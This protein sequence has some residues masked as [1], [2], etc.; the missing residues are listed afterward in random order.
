M[1]CNSRIIRNSNFSSRPMLG[2]TIVSYVEDTLA[3][4]GIPCKE[5]S[6]SEQL[7][8]VRDDIPLVRAES[9][10]ELLSAST[11]NPHVMKDEDLIIALAIPEPFVSVHLLALSELTSIEE[12]VMLLEENGLPAKT[13]D[14]NHS[15]SHIAIVDAYEYTN[16]QSYLQAVIL[17]K[18]MDNGVLFTNPEN[19][20]ISP[21]VVIGKGTLVYGGNVLE[22]KTIIGSECILYPNNRMN[23]AFVGDNSTV[24]SSVLLD[25]KVGNSTTVGPYA[26]V[27]PKSAIGN[28]CRIGDFVEVKNSNIGDGTKVSHL[29]YVGDSDLGR[30]INL[31]CG[32]VFVNY[33]GKTKRRSTIED[34]AFIGCNSN[35]IAPVNVGENAYIAAGSTVTED[36]PN[37]SLYVARSRSAIKSDWVKRRKEEG[38]L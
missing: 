21:E 7:L 13:Y 18:H 15:D 38:K 4:A 29:T 14:D 23:N 28:S 6:G 12:A 34:Y 9:F 36:V 27:R 5:I 3:S 31:G 35:L 22:G 20:Q 1:K 32:V 37:D 19:V 10:T 17:S 30:N 24:E 16:A 25:C 33:D 8:L 26:Y 2:K 11:F